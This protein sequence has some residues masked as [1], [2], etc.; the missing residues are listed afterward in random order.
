MRRVLRLAARG[1]GWTSPNPMVGAVLV[2]DGHI[3]GEGF[4]TAVGKRHAEREALADARRR[5]NDPAGATMYV[6]LEPCCHYGRTPPCTDAIMEAGVAKV[7]VAHQDPN[8]QVNGHGLTILKEA[9]LE[10]EVGVLAD[11]AIRL[12]QVYCRYI[13]SQRPFVTLKAATTLDG[14]IATVTGHSKW[15]SGPAALRY[16]HHLRHVNDAVLVGVD[17][18]IADD[19][20]LTCRPGVEQDVRQPLRVVVDSTLRT[21]ED[22]VIVSGTLPAQTVI[23]T[24]D[25]SDSEKRKRLAKESVLV[26][27][28]P[29]DE[30]GRVDLAALLVWLHRREV[31]GLLV[32]GGGRVHASF[33]RAG[34]A[35][36]LELVL[37][38]KLVGGE[39]GAS[40]M[41]GVLAETMNE[42]VVLRDMR[43]RQL[44]SDWLIEGLFEEVGGCLLD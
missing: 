28:F 20:R 43:V 15:V 34:L 8:P 40:W 29:A 13:C 19:P 41:A 12:N 42:A 22:S 11:E 21:P 24:T 44:G 30:T 5:G 32:E 4:H 14:K 36:K 35:D 33:V 25:R 16:A 31:A 3:I 23:A 2:K 17:T 26:K 38:P 1:R 18:V 7:V 9:G 27:R 37:A 6:N 39:G 10:V